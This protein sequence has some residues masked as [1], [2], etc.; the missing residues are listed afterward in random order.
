[1][2]IN[3]FSGRDEG[4]L[5]ACAKNL[6]WLW[7]DSRDTLVS[8]PAARFEPPKGLPSSGCHIQ[9]KDAP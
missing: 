2:R 6:L 7:P 9:K 4:L 8:T 5:A 1:M 3:A